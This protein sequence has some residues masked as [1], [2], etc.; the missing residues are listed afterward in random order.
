MPGQ[1]ESPATP[2]VLYRPGTV[3]YEI[4]LR[5]QRTRATAV[6]AGDAPE[7]LALLQHPPTF[8]LGRR[9][10][11]EHLL[12]SADELA[13][14]GAALHEVERGGDITFHG[15]GQLVAYP[16][17]DLRARGLGP[18]SYVR[19]LEA[20]LLRTAAMYSIE[21]HID[22]G[23]PG[24]WVDGPAGPAKLAAI[25]VRV[26]HGVSLHGLALNVSTDLGW[27]DAIVPCGIADAAVTS[28]SAL[29]EAR[30]VAPP[31]H[32]AVEEVLAAA[33]AEALS[34]DLVPVAVPEAGWR[35]DEALFGGLFGTQ[36]AAL[37]R[38]GLETGAAS[39]A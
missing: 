34:L 24:A 29:L 16:I 27:F 21:A 11:R 39:H 12:V 33:L 8:T 14:R 38:E 4:A 2:T 37:S 15:P 10:G 3:D 7:A 23:R 18:S 36:A 1:L 28:L 30:G 9:G 31:A 19:A 5:W 17:L 32:S 13:R 6:A 22:P 26:Q 25:G 20:A 35:G